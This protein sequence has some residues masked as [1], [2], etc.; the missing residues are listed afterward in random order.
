MPV[1]DLIWT[2]TTGAGATG[3]SSIVAAP[4]D[5]LELTMFLTVD[6]PGTVGYKI[7]LEFDRDGANELDLVSVVNP[8]PPGFTFSIPLLTVSD[9]GTGGPTGRIHSFNALTSFPFPGP[10]AVSG[11]FAIGV[12]EFSVN[13]SVAN[14]GDD[15]FSGFLNPT[16]ADG[17]L[18]ATGAGNILVVDFR[19]AAVNVPEPGTAALLLAG[20][21][22][23]AARTRRHR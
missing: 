6:P 18:D 21:V 9:S 22:A 3:G 5:V 23:L 8:I 7:S 11:T 12:V 20:L 15:V 4:G 1:V 14:D 13:G 2:A 19:G 16:I 10:P 17:L